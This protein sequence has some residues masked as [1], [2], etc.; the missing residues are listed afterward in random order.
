MKNSDFFDESR[1]QSQT[2]ARIVSKY[3]FGWANVMKSR[4]PSG[5][6]AYIDLFAG[7]GRYKDGTPS[8][9]LLVLNRL[10]SSEA[11]QKTVVT[12]FSEKNPTNYSTLRREVFALPGIETL[13]HQP[14]V[15]N[16]E[17]GDDA[18]KLFEGI[19]MVPSLVF[20]DPCG[21]K[22][23]S[24]D[25]VN[26][27]IKDRGCECIFF[28][29][30]NRIN[31]GLSNDLVDHHMNQIFGA[32]VATDLRGCLGPM[33]PDEREKCILK[34]LSSTVTKTYGKFV[35]LFRFEREDGT[36]TSHYLVFV[37]KHQLGY[38]IMKQIMADES[39]CSVQGVPSY[40]YAPAKLRQ[41]VLLHTEC[42]LDDL[43]RSLS[44]TF[45]GRRMMMQVIHEK[46]NVGTPYVRRN[47]KD[48]LLQLEKDGAVTVERPSNRANT[49]GDKA[50]ITFTR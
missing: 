13:T 22:G 27:V 44:S 4:S 47:Y 45:V 50:T 2:K 38:E 42:P 17:V 3:F 14:K 10:L 37:S 48:A 25:L 41:P 20:I 8:T 26:A 15:L 43:K 21:Y 5:K 40:E 23:L 34:A 35:L 19:Q 49:L 11:L 16:H 6:I 32:E 24:L 31:A 29:N 33:S 12:I 30:Y 7:T 1:E 9:P 18:A 36:R 39:S 46:H 28:F